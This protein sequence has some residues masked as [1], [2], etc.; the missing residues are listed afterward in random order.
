MSDARVRDV[1]EEIVATIDNNVSDPN[2]RRQ[3]NG[4]SWVFD[5]FPKYGKSN[6]LPR[7]GVHRVTSQF[8]AEGIN[9]GVA[10]RTESDVQVSVFVRK[11][12][13]YDVDND[14]SNEVAEDVLDY[15]QRRVKTS[16]ENNHGNFTGLTGVK[17]VLLQSSDTVR[18]SNE[19][20]M[21]AGLTYEVRIGG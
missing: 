21:F 11:G 7:I 8:P 4:D 16:I 5:H 20:W 1:I 10:S 17:H 15:L 9:Q 2:T 6:A 18:P 13:R 19:S 3:S 14:G 12:S